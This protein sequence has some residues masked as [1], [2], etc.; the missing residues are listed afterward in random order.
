MIKKLVGYVIVADILANSTQTIVRTV[1]KVQKVVENTDN[2]PNTVVEAVKEKP[3]VQITIAD[4]K[5]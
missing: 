4:V 3:K 5:K 2:T 1:T